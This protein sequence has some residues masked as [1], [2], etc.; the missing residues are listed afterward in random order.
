MGKE[1]ERPI[2]HHRWNANYNRREVKRLKEERRR[3]LISI[4]DHEAVAK[5]EDAWAD[6]LEGKGPCPA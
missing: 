1:I 3:M 5:D 6:Y 4:E 2:T